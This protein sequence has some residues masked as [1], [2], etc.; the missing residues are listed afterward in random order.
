VYEGTGHRI[1]DTGYRIQD[2]GYRKQDTGYRIQKTGHRKHVDVP[3][4][5]ASSEQVTL[6]MVVW[7]CGRM[8]DPRLSL[9]KERLGRRCAY[10]WE[11]GAEQE[12]SNRRP[13]GGGRG[14][15]SRYGA[16]AVVSLSCSLAVAHEES[17]V[18]SWQAKARRCSVPRVSC[19]VAISRS[20]QCEPP[21]PR[22]GA[23]G[24][25]GRCAL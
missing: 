3:K 4:R 15:W 12:D 11:R 8:P 20:R 24:E 7:L 17:G 21:L 19:S 18:G 16:L 22:E 13:G 5:F 14:G 6:L 10:A 1:Q 23:V 2:T 9:Y 25:K